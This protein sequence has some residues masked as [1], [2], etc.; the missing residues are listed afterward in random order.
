MHNS[1][2]GKYDN[3]YISLIDTTLVKVPQS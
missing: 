2:H 3:Q 1:A